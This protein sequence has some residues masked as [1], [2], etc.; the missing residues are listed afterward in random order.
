MSDA[1]LPCP[2]CATELEEHEL[3]G[4]DVYRCPQECG[5]TVGQ[6][7]MLPLTQALAKASLECIDPHLP[8]Q[9][10]PD[11]PNE[12]APCP[13]CQKPMETFGYLE[14]RFAYLDRCKTC[15]V[16]WIDQAEL[17]TVVR[18]AARNLG[19]LKKYDDSR[20]ELSRHLTALV[21]VTMRD[22]GGGGV[23]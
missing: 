16:V 9:I 19:Q 2:R 12:V 6:N 18:L 20:R 1:A 21:W 4:I 14:S 22:I 10:T 15:Q 8:I 11:H 5:L 17:E 3:F 7:R 23:L 13:G